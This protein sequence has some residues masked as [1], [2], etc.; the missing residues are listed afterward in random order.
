MSIHRQL[1]DI[2]QQG[3]QF[4]NIDLIS[5]E[6]VEAFNNYATEIKSYL[7]HH[8]SNELVHERLIKIQPIQYTQSKFPFWFLLTLILLPA[9]LYTLWIEHNNKTACKNQLLEI[10]SIFA[11]IEFLLKNDRF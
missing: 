3:Q 9:Y 1:K 6:S 10:T 7:A 2:I 8:T 11:S 4:K 5:E